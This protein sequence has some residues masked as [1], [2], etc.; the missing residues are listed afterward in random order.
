MRAI[1]V[2]VLAMRL[3][4]C[5]FPTDLPKVNPT[6]AVNLPTTRISVAQLLPAGITISDNFFALSLAPVT[7]S[8]TLGELCPQC[9]SA[10]GQTAPKPAFVGTFSANVQLPNDVVEVFVGSGWL[11][12]NATHAF[13]F[14]PI[15]PAPGVNGTISFRV[16]G[17]TGSQTTPVVLGSQVISGAERS[18]PPG[19]TLT[20]SIAIQGLTG[21]PITIEVE[22]NSPAGG[23]TQ[24]NTA[25]RIT[26]TAAPQSLLLSSGS[27]RV[28]NR[29]IS[30]QHIQINLTGI[31]QFLIN[32]V[33]G[34]RLI[35]A[36]DNPF[37]VSGPL[38]L[39]LSGGLAPVTKTVQLQPGNST[40]EVLLTER[41][42]ESVLGHAVVLSVTGPISA[43]GS[44]VITPSSELVLTS[45]LVLEIGA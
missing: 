23:T 15:R 2:L 1:V 38:T 9:A 20:D 40:I 42:L 21:A 37:N 10:N 36:V 28:Q 19:S 34:G 8:R 32:R 22:V 7:F 30:A 25:S 13:S 6:F 17:V 44:V 3:A 29:Q 16:L 18:F 14:D 26:V 43:S 45:R 27:V 41:D 5:D 35:L 12:F 31:D 11:R 24:I 4:A 39:T 33:R